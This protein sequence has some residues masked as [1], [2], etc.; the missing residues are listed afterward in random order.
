MDR[1]KAWNKLYD[2][3]YRAVE[4]GFDRGFNNEPETADGGQLIA[5]QKTL[6]MMNKFTKSNI[7]D[8]EIS[9]EEI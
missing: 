6:D 3:I 5:Y 4:E 2:E 7:D 9:E 1:I 8:E